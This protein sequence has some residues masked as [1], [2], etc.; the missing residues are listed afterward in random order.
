M[1]AVEWTWAPFAALS[2]REVYELLSLRQEIFIVEQKCPYHDADGLDP[3]ARHLL[4]RLPAGELVA[5]ARVLPAGT[6]LAQASIGRVVVRKDQR[7][8]G[9]GRALM[10]E[11]LARIA[12]DDGAIDL[13]LS[14]QAQLGSFYASL[15]FVP[16]GER[17]DEDG[18]P[19][20]MMIR[21][22]PRGSQTHEEN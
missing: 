16:T 7:G 8:A 1:S 20:V 22:A 3:V 21:R 2:G 15:G 5:Y 4:G 12:G 11:A 13:A 10:N 6:R 14:A 19:H 18:I 17:F 9:L